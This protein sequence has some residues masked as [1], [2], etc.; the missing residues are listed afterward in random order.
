MPT[1]IGP[2]EIT[3]F[4]ECEQNSEVQGYFQTSFERRTAVRKVEGSSPRPDQH[5][6]S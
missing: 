6:G 1:K 5:S 4:G 3:I 2:K